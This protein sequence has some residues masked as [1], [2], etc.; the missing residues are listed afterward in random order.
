MDGFPLGRIEESSQRRSI[1]IEEGLFK[2]KI[3]N[4][5]GFKPN[6]GKF[7]FHILIRLIIH[8]IAAEVF[9][10]GQEADCSK[11]GKRDPPHLPSL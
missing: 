6:S 5:N 1:E 7:S 10:S 2:A 9:S 4:E 3:P 11:L 8:E